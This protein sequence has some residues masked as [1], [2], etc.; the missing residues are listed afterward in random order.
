M[1]SDVRGRAPG[2]A[3]DPPRRPRPPR[4]RDRSDGLRRR[5]RSDP[6]RHGRGHAP[7]AQCRQDV[8][9][10]LG[11]A[12]PDTR[13]ITSP[14]RLR[15]GLGRRP[16]ARLRRNPERLRSSLHLLHHPF[17][18]RRL[19]FDAARADRGRDPPP[20][21]G[22]CRG[23]RV[24]GRR[25]HLLRR[26]RRAAARR[27]AETRAARRA[28]SQ[29]AAPVLHRLYRGRSRSHGCGGGRAPLHAASA[30]VAAARLGS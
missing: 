24:D 10:R 16:Y 8:S 11:T 3:G 17:R 23:S 15:P 13:W 18:P 20:G 14:A 1:R 12:R 27:I 4:C 30:P 6:R 19:A 2:P 9:R 25:C 28:G 26:R 7:A 21:G 22:G 5:G 29:A